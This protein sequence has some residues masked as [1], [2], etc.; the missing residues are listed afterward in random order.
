[1]HILLIITDYGSFNNF[2]AELVIKM[3]NEGHKVDVICSGEKVINVNDRTNFSELG[4][5]I[6]FTNFPRGFNLKKQLM[7]S[8]AINGII[9]SLK[10]DLIHVH[11]T[12][13]IFTTV[14]YNKPSYPIIGTFHGLGFPLLKGMKSYIFKLV[15]LFCLKRLDK[16]VLLNRFDFDIINRI[17]PSKAIMLNSAGLGCDLERFDLD[18][19]RSKNQDFRQKLG[20]K[21]TDFVIAFTGRFVKFKGYDLVIRSFRSLSYEYPATF[22]LILMGGYDPIHPSGLTSDEEAGVLANPDIINIG[23]TGEVEKYLSV[24]DV[25]LFP[26]IKEGMPICIIEALAMG[27]PVITANSRGCN[28]LVKDQENGI[29]LSDDP[30]VKEIFVAVNLLK[31][32]TT[33]LAKFRSNAL[34]DRFKLSRDVYINEQIKSYKSIL[35]I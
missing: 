21:E 24:T 5:N 18:K 11:F 26:S 13:G 4:I 14:L 34:N 31:N 7:A 35:S 1:M 28:D 16:A 12:T 17:D 25:F 15:E 10:P 2:L 32:S 29:L 23:F 9:N 3:I 22:K 30:T 20:I 27:V 19:V 6:N 33:T 8:K